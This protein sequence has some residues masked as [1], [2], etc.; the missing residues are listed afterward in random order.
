MYGADNKLG[1]SNRA[2]RERTAG[3][4]H[5]YMDTSKTGIC[6]AAGYFSLEMSVSA[7]GGLQNCSPLSA[8]APKCFQKHILLLQT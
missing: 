5:I 8:F 4:Y 2:E 1:Q 7:A 6:Q 3:D